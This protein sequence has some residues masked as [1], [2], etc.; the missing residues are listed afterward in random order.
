MDIEAGV[1]FASNP[2]PSINVEEEWECGFFE[3][4]STTRFLIITAVSAIS[5][6]GFFFNLLL[7]AVFQR[8]LP[9]SVYLAALSLLDALICFT[10]I[11]LFGVDAGFVYLKN[12][13]LF[14][15]YHRYIVV[16]FFLSKVVQFAIP[17]MLILATLERYVW[18]SAAQTRDF[19]KPVFSDAGRCITTV[20]IFAISVSLRMPIFFAVEVRQF[21]QCPDRFRSQS[22]YPT[23]WARS[24]HPYYVFDFHVIVALQT[25]LP[26]FILLFL[27]G[28]IIQRLL[29][30]KKQELPDAR[31]NRIRILRAVQMYAAIQP[32]LYEAAKKVSTVNGDYKQV[33]VMPENYVLLEVATELIKESLITRSCRGKRAQLR[34]AIYT[35]MAIVTSYLVC[36]GLHLL[37]TFLERFKKHLLEDP[38]DPNL[39]STFY[40]IL[41]DS[42][43]ITYLISSAIRIFI[44][45]KCNPKL[46][47]DIGKFLRNRKISL[48]F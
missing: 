20:I 35:M 12:E 2:V 25:V 23:E 11:L 26:F 5:F 48:F 27:N 42:V 14:N 1:A 36:N 17:F 37:L 40:I 13:F 3:G 22:V 19:F 47:N 18:T 15:V 24:S 32:T 21:P 46:R 16:V 29:I 8:S 9:S 30:E 39:S 10:Y 41:S 45:A 33:P 34:N 43:S 38:N 7:L 28:I 31:Q 6:F 4:Y 44:Y